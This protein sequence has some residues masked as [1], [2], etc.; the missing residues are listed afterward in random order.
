MGQDQTK[1]A[2]AGSNDIKF[3]GV[4]VTDNTGDVTGFTH[5]ANRTDGADKGN[6]KI[7]V[8]DFKAKGNKSHL[9]VL[10][11]FGH[12]G[13][14]GESGKQENKENKQLQQASN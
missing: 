2:N 1:P 9:N 4:D 12:R 3:K 6:N 11:D 10:T 14:A 7:E 8:D 5:F 13:Q